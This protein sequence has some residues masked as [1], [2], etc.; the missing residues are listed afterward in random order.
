MADGSRQPARDKQRRAASKA[1]DSASTRGVAPD[2]QRSTNRPVRPSDPARDLLVDPRRYN[3]SDSPE[4][5]VRGAMTERGDV[6]VRWQSTL[7][8]VV[9]ALGAAGVLAS[10]ARASAIAQQAP[11]ATPRLAGTETHQVLVDVIVRDGDRPVTDLSAAEF[12][13]LEDGVPQV[14]EQF[15]L[16][17]SDVPPAR[18]PEAQ[19]SSFA[20]PAR[21]A[22]PPV[23]PASPT[24]SQEA[25]PENATLAL[26]FDSSSGEGWARAQKAARD[27]L[28]R[29]RRPA[30]MVGLFVV[31]G[32]LVAVQG[33]TA[34]EQQL[35]A[36]VDKLG[37]IAPGTV[38]AYGDQ[39]R[40]AAV[41]RAAVSRAV[42]AAAQNG[43]SGGYQARAQARYM[44]I[45]QGMEDVYLALQRDQRGFATAN[46]LTAVVDALRSVPGRKAVVLFAESLFR[47]EAT[48]TLFQSIVHSANRANVAVYAIDVS[49]LA[50]HSVES[51]MRE[52]L[53]A[54]QERSRMAQEAGEDAT[55]TL[56]L[57][58]GMERV[59]D[60]VRFNPQAAL[61]WLV[62]STGGFLVRDTNDLADAMKRVDVD[63]RSYYLLGYTPSNKSYDGRFRK[64]SVKVRRKGVQV[65]ARNGYFAVH[66]AGPVL[67]YVA[68]ALAI[69]EN[70]TRARAF[71]LAAGAVPFA[72]NDEI[73]R[74]TLAVAAPC[75][76]L[77]RLADKQKRRRPLDLTL[78]ARVRSADGRAVDT[79]SRRFLVDLGRTQPQ[80]AAW[81]LLRDVWLPAGHYTLEV[82][83]YEAHMERAAV[84]H[85]AFDVVAPASP[86]DHAQLVLVAEAVRADPAD[87]DLTPGHPLRYGEVVLHPAL[88]YPLAVSRAR[89]LVFSL[90]AA[91]DGVGPAPAATIELWVNGR[92]TSAAKI[93]WQP[94]VGG[95][96]QSVAEVPWPA[97]RGPMEVR[98]R[99]VAEGGERIIRVSFVG[100]E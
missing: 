57:L 83:A 7:L 69:L 18:V 5:I 15:V 56:S 10:A 9:L 43:G 68:P 62:R 98:A 41:R 22:E 23:L 100:S 91:S 97:E 64:I 28:T 42:V 11:P 8:A 32:G 49:G 26:V 81:R 67:A 54:T 13:V 29:S 96:F 99:L 25:P 20:T 14:I 52:E 21:S 30:D 1:G 51:G 31:S 71:E 73:G 84:S 75:A 92:R 61:E 86:L 37:R 90:S 78:L 76:P 82:V 79:V 66:S 94:A 45:Q 12:E 46:A 16:Q 35:R 88:G 59:T 40:A 34:D 39:V 17:Q 63:L 93:G 77:A 48:E 19:S 53:E 2:R 89:P 50:V 6:E 74:V 33:F 38:M 60:M 72:G 44:S 95:L 3:S 85:S 24:T 55:G 4:G 58:R 27:F 65:R 47:T 87:A 36:G 80:G 70:G